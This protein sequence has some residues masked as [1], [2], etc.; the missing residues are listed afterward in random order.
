[1]TSLIIHKDTVY[2]GGD[3]FIKVYYNKIIICYVKTYKRNNI[4]RELVVD[5]S[6]IDVDV[7]I[8]TI[9]RN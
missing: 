7:D 2:I 6:D 3:G 4:I 1:M 5:R 9:I 8:E